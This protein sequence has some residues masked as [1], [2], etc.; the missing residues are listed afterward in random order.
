MPA[1]SNTIIWPSLKTY[2]EEK[3]S[4]V[5][6]PIGGIG[7]GTVS[8]CGH[9]A[10]RN[11]EVANRPAKGFTPVGQG[12][13]AP[14]FALRT[15]SKG[16]DPVVRLLEGP[17]PISER[18]GA[19]GAPLPNA[20]LPRF[21]KSNFHAAY[22]LGQ[23]ELSD[24][25]VPLAVQMQVFN[26]LIPGDS[27]QSGL[28]V[29]M[30]RIKLRNDTATAVQAS[31]AAALP[32]FI[33]SDGFALELDEFRGRLDP[34]GAKGGVNT[35]RESKKLRGVTLQSNGVPKTESTWGTLALAT[36]ARRGVSHRTVWAD[37]D[38]SDALLEFWDD[39]SQDGKLDARASTSDTPTASLA[40]SLTV[41][42]A[43]EKTVEFIVAWH[44]PNRKAWGRIP[45]K[46]PAT[47][48][49]YYT[50]L[51]EDAWHAAEHA[52]ENWKELEQQTVAFVRSITDSSLP[53]EVQEAALFNLSTLRSQTCFRTPDERFFGWEG[54]FDRQ[55]SCHGN[56]TH[57]WNYE[58]ATA[59]LF[60]DLARSMRETEFSTYA[61]RKDGL[62]RFRVALPLKKNT[63]SDLAAADGQMGCLIKLHREWR[64]S[65]DTEWLRRLWPHAQKVMEFAWLPGSWDADQDGVMEGCQHNTM[66]VEYF[67]PNPQ[68]A[69]WYLGALY[70]CESMARALDQTTFADKCKRL[71]EQGRAWIDHHLFNGEYYEHHI[72]PLTSWDEI[73][74]GLA[75]GQGTKDVAHP[76]FQLGAGCL[77][78]QLAGQA[79]AHFE[80]F[81]AL[82]DPANEEAALR[83]VL[84]YNRRTNFHAHFNHMR[85]YALGDETAV[86]MAS[87]PRGNRPARPFPYY[88]EV[89]TGFEY[90]LAISL[91]QVG[92]RR[93]G[94]K[95]VRDIRKRY[96]GRKRNPFDE[97]ECGH[98]YARALASWG[99]IPA[100]SGFY[101]SAVNRTFRVNSSSQPVK[102]PWAAA[103][104][105]GTI[106]ISPRKH[107]CEVVIEVIHGTLSIALFIL[108]GAGEFNFTRSR[109]LAAGRR[110]NFVVT[111]TS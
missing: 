89:M 87:Y 78:D 12:R 73:L 82:L 107:T 31:I 5:A 1:P 70:A 19:E 56:C 79:N 76:E 11:W 90:C 98:H 95:I 68:M 85:A 50:T 24:G 39:L 38:W 36:T 32:N 64:L 99:L 37:Y 101:Y 69:T 80:G 57:V 91:I 109:N 88:T 103:G 83:S 46:T 106:E 104:T 21:R 71:Y 92:R 74:P 51:F 53:K 2:A 75:V 108:S 65:G 111:I 44:F 35:Y 42:P 40:V 48:G 15:V 34:T 77:I 55:G 60:P 59:N 72:R 62:M 27:T 105:W 25:D 54:N 49:N 67:G 6:L 9:G 28:P 45:G 33:G 43:S 41:P 86:L 4:R 8:F 81:G 23:L 7:T 17:N 66:D 102:W 84:K 3:S 22:P 96:D 47:I 14:F 10:W 13:A 58:H 29:A 52:A 61:M 63:G 18:E 30:V 110:F 93:D 100:L 97:A 16:S 94:L 26:P 20:G